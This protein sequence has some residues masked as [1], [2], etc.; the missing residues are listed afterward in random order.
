MSDTITR[1]HL[2]T[3]FGTFKP[4]GHVMM[5]LPSM[6]QVE[7]LTAALREAGWQA[8]ELVIFTPR[9][10]SAEMDA[11]VDAA[12]PLAGFGYEITLQRRYIELARQGYG[13]L[14]VKAEDT[15][16]ASRAAA[17]AREHG[18]RLAVHYRLLVV[19]ELI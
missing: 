10:S 3:S 12:S 4:T 5:G 18:A 2:P 8:G 1:E 14:L 11:L 19:E 16:T 6:G 9:E 13:W 17:I 15:D 7:S